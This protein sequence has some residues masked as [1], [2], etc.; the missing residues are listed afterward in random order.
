MIKTPFTWV[1]VCCVPGKSLGC[2][3][4]MLPVLRNFFNS[5]PMIKKI[6]SPV[7]S[8]QLQFSTPQSQEGN[9]IKNLDLF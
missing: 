7:F 8:G 1:L 9:D 5:A 4:S 2:S 3:G 6:V